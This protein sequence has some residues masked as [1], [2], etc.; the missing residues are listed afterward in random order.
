MQGV[1]PTWVARQVLIFWK[2]LQK[3]RAGSWWGPDQPLRKHVAKRGLRPPWEYC[4]KQGT[5]VH[6][7]AAEVSQR[8]PGLWL[9]AFFKESLAEKLDAQSQREVPLQT[10]GHQAAAVK[11]APLP[12]LGAQGLVLHP[13]SRPTGRTWNI[14]SCQVSQEDTTTEQGSPQ[15]QCPDKSTHGDP[16]GETAPRESQHPPIWGRRRGLGLPLHHVLR[17]KPVNLFPV[18]LSLSLWSLGPTRNRDHAVF[19][20]LRLTSLP[21]ENAPRAR[22]PRHNT[23]T[24]THGHSLSVDA[25]AALP[26]LG[27]R[28]R[29]GG[30]RG[31]VD[32]SEAPDSLPLATFSEAGFLGHALAPFFT[33]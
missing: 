14:P 5:D 31:G 23:H 1:R 19:V 6:C 24:H 8:C 10:R 16:H 4:Q 28:G 26:G 32:V 25:H 20:C 17:K 3:P 30:E 2:F 12:S 22:P 13:Q 11:P 33:F 21:E 7:R 18:S 9:G 27:R 29:C 15:G